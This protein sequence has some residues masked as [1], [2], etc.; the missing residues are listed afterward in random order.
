MALT[1][2]PGFGI[3]TSTFALTSANITGNL[4]AGNANLGNLVTAN[5][6]SGNGSLLTGITATILANGNSNVNIP[7][8]NGNVTISAV[9]NAN[10]IVVTGTGVN[11][12]GYLTASGNITSANANLGNAVTGNY[13][14]GSGNNL[15]NI[16]G[17]N[18]TGQVSNATVAGT[19]YTNAQPNI[20]SLGTL[21]N[22]VV[23]GNATITGNLTVSGNTTYVNS[24]VTYIEDPLIELGGGANG[25]S[26]TSNDGYDR[27]TVLHYYTS[28]TVDA[29]MGWKNA[30]GEF[31]FASNA[32]LSSNN[33]TI[34]TLG[35][36]RAGNANLGNIVTAN[37]VTG[38]LTTNAQPNIT[39]VGTLASLTVTGNITSGNANL[40][41]TV[42][43]NY[44]SG[45]GSLLTGISNAANANY[46]NYAGI[47]INGTQSNITQVGTLT[48][49]NVSGNITSGNANLGN[50]VTANYF[51]GNGS[52]LTG[53]SASTATSLVAG[54]SNVVLTPNANI[55]MGVAGN[56]NVVIVTGSGVN[57]SGYTTIVG[58]LVAS[59]GSLGNLVTA[60]YFSGN[61][62]LLTGVSTMSN[63]NSNV[64]VALN[65][66]VAISAGGTYDVFYV[67]NTGANVSGTFGVTGT[68]TVNNLLSN[69]YANIT[70]IIIAANA[71]LGNIANANYFNG[72]FTSL[73]G[74]QPNIQQVG[75]LNYLNVSN[76]GSGNGTVTANFVNATYL[77][78]DGSNLTGIGGAAYI[79]NVNSN[80][81]VPVANGNVYVTIGSTSNVVVFST[82]GIN[83]NGSANFT[84]NLTVGGNSNLGNVATA[85]Y[86]KGDGSNL[87]GIGG[88]GYIF[89]ANSNVAIPAA[90]SNIYFTVGA[91]SNV[92]MISNLGINANGYANFT[93][94]LAVGGNANITGTANITANT[95]IGG[96]LSVTANITGGNANLGNL[97]TA[98]YF[99]GTLTTQNQPNIVSVGTLLNVIVSNFA[100]IG[101]NLFVGNSASNVLVANTG[102]IIAT[103]NITAANANLGNV[104]TAN[105]TNA[106]LTTGAQPNITSIGTLGNLIVTNNVSA[107]TITTGSGTNANLTIDPD[108]TGNLVITSSTPVV[109]SNTLTSNGNVAFSGANISLGAVGNVKITG[110]S[111][112]QY[113]KTDGTGNL[114]WGTP[115]G[116]GGGGG[117]GLTYTAAT[118]PPGTPNIADQWYNTTTNV[119]YEYI[120][121]GTTGYW[122]DIQTPTVS[123]VVYSSGSSSFSLLVQNSGTNL[124]TTANTLNFTGSGVTAT[125]SGNVVTVT[126]SG[127]SGGGSSTTISNG[128][129][130]VNIASANGNVTI[131]A[132]GNSNIV[133]VT[134]TGVNVSGY[135]TS[136]GNIVAAN[137]NLGNLI[138]ANYITVSSNITSGNANLGNAVTSNYFIGNGYYL[139]GISGGGGSSLAVQL[140]GTTLASAASTINFVGGGDSVTASSSTVTVNQISPFLLMG[141]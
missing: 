40:G 20:T 66:T 17:G 128:N 45:N 12:T 101:G 21:S 4:T 9:G 25:A 55:N 13:F 48:N 24:N 39:S 71:N 97:V 82:T 77:K 70:G 41:N 5:Y 44:F 121:D 27:G 118:S 74:N 83:A 110:G 3:D 59:N 140:Q 81:F 67:N 96:N 47:V 114:S 106:V 115:S 60:N 56:S 103:G 113:L 138:T 95:S 126:I 34:N 135:L 93:G 37:Y 42:T 54:N 2:I 58:N 11:V 16:Q 65:S 8:G 130:N 80:V 136:T 134:G 85:N 84:G 125:N 64:T 91:T 28:T 124:T 99:T 62:S 33:V 79:S 6:F 111:T 78:G 23:S 18:V 73:A 139:T 109:M 87:T 29:F 88:A 122:V 108:G 43:A 86:F 133:T 89:N 53:L 92:V 49:L 46:S 104:V 94:N 19:V 132:V 127:G 107:N 68:A 52:Q 100:N 36:I 72:T 137:A 76:A 15:S 119:L 141:A 120:S 31:V 69:G 1:K 61:G 30:N 117:T 63:G 22:L 57:I 102:V 75:T 129:S 51:I 131:S 116:G 35:N 98:N 112:N 26:L 32:S 123:S 14:I 38:T 10:I 105:Y 90:N 50:T 7:I